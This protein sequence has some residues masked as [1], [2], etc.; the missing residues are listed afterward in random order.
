MICLSRSVSAAWADRS[1]W[2]IA[3]SVAVSSGRVSTWVVIEEDQSIFR[4]L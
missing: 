3:F 1:A 2:S 4:E